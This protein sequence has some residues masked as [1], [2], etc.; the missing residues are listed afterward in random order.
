MAG[1][2]RD[3]T[4]L[5]QYI[6]GRGQLVQAG[7]GTFAHIVKKDLEIKLW[8]V[9]RKQASQPRGHPFILVSLAIEH[10]NFGRLY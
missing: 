4:N 3:L 6:Q 5:A 8:I 2:L 9:G 10:V 1:P 7:E